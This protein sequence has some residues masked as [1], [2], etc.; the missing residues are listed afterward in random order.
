M[1]SS[2][3][4]STK[5]KTALHYDGTNNSQ[6]LAVCITGQTTARPWLGRQ[7]WLELQPKTVT[8]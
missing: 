4:A 2:Y 1:N 6:T 3:L 7:V 8:S 5:L